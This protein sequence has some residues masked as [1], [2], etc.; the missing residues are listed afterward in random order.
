MTEAV[1]I[2]ILGAVFNAGIIWGTM[3]AWIGRVERVEKSV[4][5]AHARIDELT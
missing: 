4:D 1:A 3:R 5:R 2:A